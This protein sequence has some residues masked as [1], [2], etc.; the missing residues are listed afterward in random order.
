MVRMVFFGARVNLSVIIYYLSVI[1]YYLNA[2][3][4]HMSVVIYHLRTHVYYM[5]ILIYHL[6]V[7]IYRLSEVVYQ[8]NAFIYYMSVVIYHLTVFV[9]QKTVVVSLFTKLFNSLFMYFC[10]NNKRVTQRRKGRKD[11]FKIKNVFLF[12]FYLCALCAFA[13]NKHGKTHVRNILRL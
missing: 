10:R 6:T 4:Y 12:L 7:V 2:V 8:M 13:R 3:V 5:S 11:V 9:W 1:I